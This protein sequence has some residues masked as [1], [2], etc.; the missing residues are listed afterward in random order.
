MAFDIYRRVLSNDSM[1]VHL[2]ATWSFTVIKCNNISNI[3]NSYR[4]AQNA[5][6]R[7][8]IVNFTKYVIRKI[9]KIKCKL[10]LDFNKW[11]RQNYTFY[12]CFVLY[13]R[14]TRAN[15]ISTFASL[16]PYRIW[17]LQIQLL[18]ACI[19]PMFLFVLLLL[20]RK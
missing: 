18:F 10:L 14:D 4:K 9:R 20:L 17:I 11:Q 12:M 19:Y 15:V 13:L 2:D 8:R 3:N 6:P 16:C 1:L 5:R 7:K